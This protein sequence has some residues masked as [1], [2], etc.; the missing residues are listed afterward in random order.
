MKLLTHLKSLSMTVSLAGLVSLTPALAADLVIGSSTEP[1]ALD[2]HFSRTGNN[3]NV[4]A[5]IFDRLITPDP[6]LQVTP[7]LA[8][9]WENVDPTTWRIKLRSGVKF[10]DGSPLTAEDVIF[11]LNRVKDIPNSPAPFTGNIGAIDSMT[12]VDPRTIEFKTKKPTPDFIEQVGLVYI[13][14]KKLAEGKSIEA[15]NDRSAAVGTGPYTVKEWVP[16]DHITLKRNDTYWG[17]KP[18]YENVTIKFIAND[19]ARVAALRSGSVDLID[20]VPPGDVKTLS[21]VNNIKLWS[22]PSG[23]V[24]YLALDSSRDES[25]F[26]VGP[27][28][29]PLN[30]NPLKDVRIRQAL[31]KLIDRQLIVDRIIDG[32]GEPAGQIVPEGIGGAD[33][34]LKASAPDVAGAKKLLADAGYPQGFGLTIHTSND[35]FAGDAETAQAIGQ[36]FA[37]GGIKVNGV[38][39]QPYNVYASAAGK[40]QF[41]AFI[42]SLGTTT[43]TSATNLRNL[44]MTPDKEAGTGSFNRT[45]Y[46]NKQYD[47]K[48]REATS[49]FDPQKRVALLQEATRIAMNDVGVIPLFWPKVYWASK[50]NVTY[51]P[52]RGEDLMATHAGIAQ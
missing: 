6:N 24:I 29:K 38:V 2:P 4:A 7:A 44:L 34:S 9:S 43:P 14:Q 36:M 32:A 23:R 42:F 11:S 26:V 13:V 48:M 45:R 39:A 3:Q 41:S 30:P 47:E 25:P 33:P 18:A 37:R 22:I 27:D 16:G 50:A 19:A 35:R 17:K 8:E 31:S 15:F 49:E 28:G 20:A 5:Q 51:I 40:Q 52:N 10:Q 46:S 12:I 21:S 1:S